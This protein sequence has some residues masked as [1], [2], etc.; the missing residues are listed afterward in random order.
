MFFLYIVFG[1]WD[2]LSKGPVFMGKALFIILSCSL[3]NSFLEFHQFLTNST[4]LDKGFLICKT[5]TKCMSYFF[6]SFSHESQLVS[7]LYRIKY[8]FKI[9]FS[10]SFKILLYNNFVAVALVYSYESLQ[11]F[12]GLGVGQ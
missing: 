7:K 2:L 6:C 4:P 9:I 8:W 10:E 11:H 5:S 3:E 1:G 12:M